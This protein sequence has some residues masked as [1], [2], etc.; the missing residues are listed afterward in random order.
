[1]RGA[2]RQADCPAERGVGLGRVPL[3]QLHGDCRWAEAP[4][5]LPAWRQLIWS[6]IPNDRVVSVTGT[7]RIRRA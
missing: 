1:M 7:P 4:V 6:D 3:E 2:G 5:Y